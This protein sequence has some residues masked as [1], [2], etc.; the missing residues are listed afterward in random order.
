ELLSIKAEYRQA[1]SNHRHGGKK[2]LNAEAWHIAD[3]T[4]DHLSPASRPSATLSAGGNAMRNR[5]AAGLLCGIVLASLSSL[6]VYRLTGRSNPIES[7][8][9]VKQQ[10]PGTSP[11]MPPRAVP[12]QF[13][14]GEYYIVPLS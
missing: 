9:L 2:S 5:F 11:Q 7:P 10:A 6:A 12:H 8:P 1:H 13:N 3:Y 14:G 4:T